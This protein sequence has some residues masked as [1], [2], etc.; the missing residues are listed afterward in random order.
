VGCSREAQASRK[1]KKSAGR[2]RPGK[3]NRVVQTVPT[4]VVPVL[5]CAPWKNTFSLP[6]V[7]GFVG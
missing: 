6:P 3:K 5:I 7:S 1:K 4:Y 2:F